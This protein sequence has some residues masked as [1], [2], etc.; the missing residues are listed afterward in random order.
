[1]G[2]GVV[3]CGVVLC[4]VVWCAC[5]GLWAVGCLYAIARQEC[6][7]GSH[8]SLAFG[9]LEPGRAVRRVLRLRNASDVSAAVT[10][11]PVDGAASRFA[12]DPAQLT[13]AP[14]AV[15]DVGVATT[16]A[17]CGDSAAAAL[18]LAVVG[19]NRSVVL[20]AAAASLPKV[21]ARPP[22]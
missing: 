6:S 19:G 13:I 21:P 5:C 15:A 10:V 12:V 2:W 20:C 3:S 22:R 1:M 8:Y 4:G 7:H 11:R 16:L 9:E 17:A 18:E 14:R